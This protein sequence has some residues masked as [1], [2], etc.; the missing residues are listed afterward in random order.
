[1]RRGI[2]ICQVVCA[3]EEG[4]VRRARA[5]L[6]F[7]LAAA[8]AEADTMPRARVL[9]I[10][11]HLALLEE[12]DAAVRALLPR[13]RACFTDRLSYL[14]HPAYVGGLSLERV[15]GPAAVHASGSMAG[16]SS[17]TR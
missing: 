3:L 14:D 12:D 5:E 2:A 1:M 4:D 9:A 11:L 8:D 17:C 13:L 7:P 15:E 10:Y 6:D 16:S